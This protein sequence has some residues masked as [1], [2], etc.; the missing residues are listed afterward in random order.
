[1]K[2]KVLL[3]LLV[4]GAIAAVLGYVVWNKPHE[5]VDDKKG[6]QITAEA[7]TNAF[8]QN[9]L[10]AN[11]TYLNQVI[12]VSGKVSEISKNQDGKDVLLLESSDPLSGV[13]CTMRE[14]GNYE[15]EKEITIKG[16]CNGYTTV[17]LLSDC[18]L[19]K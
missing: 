1:M 10:S 8:L 4:V 12:E 19:S 14:P 7:L 13:Q 6:I 11:A 17:V 16:F 5:T 18:I 9:E 3:F 2:K 15:M